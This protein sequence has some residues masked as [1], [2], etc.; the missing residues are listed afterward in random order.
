MRITQVRTLAMWV[1]LATAAVAQADKFTDNFEAA[2][3]YVNQGTAASGWDGFIGLDSGQTVDA[4]TASIERPGQ[5][6]IASTNGRWQEA[7]NPLG[8]FLYKVVRGDFIATVKVTDYAGTAAASVLHNC[9]GLMARAALEDAGAGEDW[10]SIDYFPIW[11]C[12][13]FVR[14]PTTVRGRRTATMAGPGTWTPGCSLRDRGT[15][16][17]S[18]RAQ[19]A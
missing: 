19:M 15:S 1:A 4:L 11:S 9:A 16:S 13:N 8:P 10:V 14:M 7:W 2:R 18:G 5:L 6:Y 3:N 17:T 12:G